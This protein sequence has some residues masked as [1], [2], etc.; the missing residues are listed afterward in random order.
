[1]AGHLLE[2]IRHYVEVQEQLPQSVYTQQFLFESCGC[3]LL[4]DFIRRGCGD[5]G[6]RGR[7]NLQLLLKQKNDDKRR[8]EKKSIG[9]G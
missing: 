8:Q 3:V 4:D 1:M 7:Q 5:R 6:D 9:V 2:K